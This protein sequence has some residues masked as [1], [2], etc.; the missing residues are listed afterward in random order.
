MELVSADKIEGITCD[1]ISVN[2]ENPKS[3]LT[4]AENL[5]NKAIELEGVGLAAPQVGIF[6]KIHVWKDVD[7][8]WNI[9]INPVYYPDS[10]AKIETLEG[11]LSY[12]E[13]D[14][15]LMKRY[16]RIIAVYFTISSEENKFVRINKKLTG[17]NAIAFQHET[18]HINGETIATKGTWWGNY[19]NTSKETE[20]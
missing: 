15:Y 17:D 20:D 4:L 8:E 5:V 1:L 6:R 7:H 3:I 18:D 13:G 11:C 9:S 16:K 2:S 10:K 14:R 12:V 19:E